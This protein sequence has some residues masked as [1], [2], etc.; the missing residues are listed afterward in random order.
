MARVGDRP[1]GHPL[2]ASPAA[3]AGA[4][5]GLQR[6]RGWTRPPTSVN[7][8]ERLPHNAASA[9]RPPRGA[10]C[11]SW[12][13]RAARSMAFVS[14]D[15]LAGFPVTLRWPVAWGDMDALGHVNNT[16][17][18]RWFESVRIG[19]FARIGW[20]TDLSSGGVGPILAQTSCTYR[21]PLVFPDE[22]V[23]AARV[24][25]VGQ[26]RFTMRYRVVSQRLG[27]VAADGEARVVSFDYG[28]GTKAALPE[29][30]RAAIADLEGG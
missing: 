19:Y 22:V 16:T 3:P 5:D 30:V 17:Y 13:V 10:R 12:L 9:V 20:A 25:D 14:D 26:D 21:A 6:V 29:G 7:A 28:A 2:T 23:L 8:Q 27:L 11:P 1:A 18:F 15:L 4:S 24:E